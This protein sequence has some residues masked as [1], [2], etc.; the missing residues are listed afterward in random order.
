MSILRISLFGSLRIAHDNWAK[1]LTLP[2]G[3]MGLLVYLLLRRHRLHPREVLADV[4]W[5]ENSPEKARGSLNTA[6]WRLRNILE[7]DGV[8]AGT[9]LISTPSGEVGFNQASQ[10]WLNIALFEEMVNRILAVPVQTMDESSA[11]E[12]QSVLDLYTA[13][14]LE[15]FYEDWVLRERERLRGLYIKSLMYLLQYDKYNHQYQKA[16]SHGQRI[17]DFDPLR[18][19]IH[20]EMMR[21]YIENGQRTQAIRQYSI[22]QKILADELGIPPMPETQ[23]LYKQITGEPSSNNYFQ[24]SPPEPKDLAQALQQL[25]QAIEAIKFARVQIQQAVQY[26]ERHTG[27]QE[28]GISLNGYKLQTYVEQEYMEILP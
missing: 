23:A 10:Y 12:L 21:L 15:G 16:L 26:I 27:G 7:P 8:P 11:R 9:Y 6:L 2:R 17:L 4:F 22:C 5:G 18:E 28:N 24:V 19:E 3:V 14:L 1:E 20:R 13:D 25:T